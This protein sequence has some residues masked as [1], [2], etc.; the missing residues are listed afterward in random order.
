MMLTQV[1]D[2]LIMAFKAQ[3]NKESGI[4]GENWIK[5]QHIKQYEYLPF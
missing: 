2:S 3:F 5:I 4:Q 1:D